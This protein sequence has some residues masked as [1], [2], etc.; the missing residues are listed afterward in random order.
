MYDDNDNI[1]KDVK[2][3]HDI[4]DRQGNRLL[5]HVIAE[6]IG[7]CNTRFNFSSNDINNII[8]NIITELEASIRERI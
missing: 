5:L 2:I 1:I 8:T 6:S 4:I 7:R 3:L